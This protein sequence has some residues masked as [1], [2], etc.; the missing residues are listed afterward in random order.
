MWVPL[1]GVS[2]PDM[3]WAILVFV[4][5]EEVVVD[6]NSPLQKAIE[7]RKF[8]YSH[9]FV[10]TNVLSSVAGG[11]LAAV[12]G[13]LIVLPVFV[14]G[15]LSHWILDLLVHLRDLPVLGFDGDRKLGLGLWRWGGLA[16][17]VELTFFTLFAVTFV[18]ASTRLSVLIVGILFHLI[19]ANSFFGFTKKNP[20]SSSDA[21]AGAALIG[22][23]A[24]GAIYTFIL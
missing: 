19:N 22:F 5:K 16:F 15:S 24:L 23:G 20:F 7:F 17:F 3:L 11:A 2:F 8:P 21:Y 12:S 4:G 9:S 18:P 14:L 10:I 13:N 6:K 1:V